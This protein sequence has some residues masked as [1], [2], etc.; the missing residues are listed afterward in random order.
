M[1]GKL[2]NG[3]YQMELDV[4]SKFSAS[5]SQRSNFSNFNHPSVFL[6]ES[7]HTCPSPIPL[8]KS[9][10]II[11]VWH[12]R[13][14]HTSKKILS[15]VLNSCKLSISLKNKVDFCD[16]CQM[17]KSHKLPFTSSLTHTSKPLQ[18]VF[19]DIGVLH[20]FYHPRAINIT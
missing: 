20:L 8:A 5:S 14:G 12:R 2:K 9:E 11:D 3:L 19:I 10:S 17:G 16:A 7:Q 15:Q 13:L 18:L 4:P 1:Q 6:V